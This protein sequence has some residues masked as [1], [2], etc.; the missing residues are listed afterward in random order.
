M[1]KRTPVTITQT[2]PAALIRV[3]VAGATCA[4]CHNPLR[5]DSRA[6]LVD[7]GRLAHRDHDTDTPPFTCTPVVGN[8]GKRKR[9]A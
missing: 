8:G 3:T 1:T 9:R 5:L 6:K 7:G 2:R 4:V